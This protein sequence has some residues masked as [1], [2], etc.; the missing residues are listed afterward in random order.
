MSNYQNDKFCEALVSLD[1]FLDTSICD[2]ASQRNF[3]NG[4][5][6]RSNVSGL[7]KFISH[8]VLFEYDLVRMTLD[9]HPLTIVDKFIQEVFWRIYWKGWL[10]HH[11]CVWKQFSKFNTDYVSSVD[12]QNAIKGNTGI[13]CFDHWVS[14]LQNSNYLHNHA[15]MWFASIWIF[16]L[17]L[18]WEAGAKF[19]LEHLYDGDAASNTLGWRW[20]AGIQTRGKH[21]LARDAN[22]DYYTGGRFSSSNLNETAEAITSLEISD[23]IKI[24]YNM[25]CSKIFDF[26][27]VFDTDL[28]LENDFIYEKYRKV[29]VVSPS[30]ESRTIPVSSEVLNFKNSVVSEFQKRCLGSEIIKAKDLNTIT[31]G[32]KGFDVV[33]P[34]IGENLD[35]MLKTSEENGVFLNYLKRSED[36]FCWQFSGKGFFNFR[37]KIPEIIDNLNLASSKPIKN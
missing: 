23:P 24:D 14:E 34:F 25:Q 32:Q 5:L 15:R 16:T 9:R 18:P 36:L 22:I 28:H 20:V 31:A 7:S 12:Y 3:D 17:R 8:R 33:Y 10:E 13:E 19:F 37:K 4:N 21:Y 26:L 1:A 35:C 2:Y 27:I 29:F 30:N 6:N 11:P